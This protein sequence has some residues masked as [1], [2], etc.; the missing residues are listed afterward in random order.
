MRSMTGFGR[1]VAANNNAD[2]SFSVEICSINR[3]QFDLR[4]VLPPELSSL[5]PLLRNTISGKISRGAVNAKVQ[6]QLG[7]QATREAVHLNSSLLEGLVEKSRQLADR[8]G[9]K[10]DVMIRDFMQIP[11]V[12][13][14]STPD[15]DLPG[16]QDTFMEA[17]T[18]AMRELISMKENEGAHIREDISARIEIL[19]SLVDEIEP[20]AQEIPEKQ[21][22]K[23]LQRLENSGLGVDCDDERILREIVIYSDKADVSEEI[24]RL[25]SHFKQFDGY[26]NNGSEPAGRSLDFLIQEFNRETTTLGNKA[27]GCAISPLVVKMKT[28]LEKIREQ[29]Q[30]IE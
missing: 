11:G 10:E 8:L 5:E 28:E 15:L 1:G 13:E 20:L 19:K 12:I 26:L 27:A 17:V 7:P 30:N 2:V 22:I 25:K 6:I 18:M 24:T 3:K 23:L 21:K 9:L 4:T 29:V 16:I 14:L